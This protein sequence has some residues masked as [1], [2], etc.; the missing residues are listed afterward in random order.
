M[1]LLHVSNVIPRSAGGFNTSVE[2]YQALLSLARSQG[3]VSGQNRGACKIC[4][5]LGHLTKQCRNHLSA[6]FQLPGSTEGAA[7]A[8]SAKPLMPTLPVVGGNDADEMSS[9]LSDLDSSSSGSQSSSESEEERR[10]RK[11][12]T[13]SELHITCIA[14]Q[15]RHLLSCMVHLRFSFDTCCLR[16]NCKLYSICKT[17]HCRKR[18]A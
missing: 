15:I 12:S 17:S 18:H 16:G 13:L 4:G 9:D 14:G 10:R 11:V 5:Q 2:D 3:A 1:R 6:H 8:A 7:A